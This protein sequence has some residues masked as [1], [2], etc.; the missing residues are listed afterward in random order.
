MSAIVDEFG[1][2]TVVLFTAPDDSKPPTSV[3]LRRMLGTKTVRIYARRGVF[4]YDIWT[5]LRAQDVFIWQQLFGG[6]P[7]NA[8]KS[9]CTHAIIIDAG[10]RH[11]DFA[12]LLYGASIVAGFNVSRPSMSC[13]FELLKL[14]DKVEE[15]RRQCRWLKD[16]AEAVNHRL[17]AVRCVDPDVSTV[18]PCVLDTASLSYGANVIKA[19]HKEVCDWVSKHSWSE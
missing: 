17:S 6:K 3:E 12:R 4:S 10:I 15:V 8:E 1:S 9:V 13:L 18:D 5:L 19:I 14:E 11:N 16:S 2:A 7:T